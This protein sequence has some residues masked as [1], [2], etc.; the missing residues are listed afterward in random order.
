MSTTR[1]VSIREYD[2]RPIDVR[3]SRLVNGLDYAHHVTICRRCPF[4]YIAVLDQISIDT[5]IMSFS[6]VGIPRSVPTFN[7]KVRG[8]NH[9]DDAEYERL[10]GNAE[11]EA[12]LRGQ[13]FEASKRAY[14]QGNGALAHE[15]SEEGKRHGENMQRANQDAALYVFRANNSA[16]APDEIDLHGLHVEEAKYYTEQRIIACKQRRE[17]HLHVIVGKGIHSVNHIQKIKP[18][19]EEL[20]RQHNFQYTTEHNEGRILVRFAPGEGMP[21]PG[22]AGQYQPQQYQQQPQQ[23]QPQ[24]GWEQYN[25]PQNRK[26]AMYWLRKLVRMFCR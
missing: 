15:K 10:R 9:A 12:N 22:S 13:C 19:I 18:A 26:K 1:H 23:Q 16:C 21:A 2:L 8:T 4:F 14:E 17:D 5:P 25:T 24:Q 20:C 11:R 3:S 6:A 7:D